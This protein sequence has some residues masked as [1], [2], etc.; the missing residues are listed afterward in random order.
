MIYKCPICNEELVQ[1]FGNGFREHDGDPDAG[2]FLNC[3][4]LKCSAQEV[5]GHG[6]NVKIAYEVILQK[7]VARKDRE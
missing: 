6:N 1:Y 4:N 3:N 2:V 5:R 7:F